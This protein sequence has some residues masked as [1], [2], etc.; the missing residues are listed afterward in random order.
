V[1]VW[2]FNSWNL[3]YNVSAEWDGVPD[4]Y[5]WVKEGG[6]FLMKGVDRNR[7]APDLPWNM[8]RIYGPKIGLSDEARFF[9]RFFR[10]DPNPKF[11]GGVDPDWNDRNE[12]NYLVAKTW[13]QRA[14]DVEGKGRIRQTIQDRSLFRSGPARSQLD[15]ATALQK[16]GFNEEYD[17]H[18]RVLGY[19]PKDTERDEIEDRIRNQLREQTREAWKIG[20][21]DWTQK[22]G[23]EMFK[24]YYI[25]QDVEFKLEMTEDEIK[26]LGKT[27]EKIDVLKRAV[28]QYQNITNYRYWRTRALSEA[29]P[30]TAE[31]HWQLF[32]AIEEMKKQNLDKAQAAAEQSMKLFEKVLEKFPMLG[33]QDDFVEEGATAVMVWQNAQKL[34]DIKPPEDFPLK[35]LYEKAQPRWQEYKDRLDRQLRP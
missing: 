9:R 35:E 11:G 28:N 2:E 7:L 8:G 21:E 10:H 27:P 32:A 15:Y 33:D 34:N 1:K 5:F 20:F 3:A 23:Q 12:D 30:D 26:D 16:Y 31:A 14:N 22:F 6:K 13:F 19:K 17:E 4:R 18:T 24:V 25:N 29:E